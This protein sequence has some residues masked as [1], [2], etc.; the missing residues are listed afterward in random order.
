MYFNSYFRHY[1][2]YSLTATPSYY[3]E[4]LVSLSSFLPINLPEKLYSYFTISDEEKANIKSSQNPRLSLLL[5][6]DDTGVINPSEV[7]ILQQPF[8]EFKLMQA[9]SKVKEYQSEVE[10]MRVWSILDNMSL[11]KKG[12]VDVGSFVLVNEFKFLFFPDLTNTKYSR[13]Q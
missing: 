1:F 4:F 12:K 11:T 3:E 7:T 9:V 8:T 2:A 5:V 6:L 10:R 13:V